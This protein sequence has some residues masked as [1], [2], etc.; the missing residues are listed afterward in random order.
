MA[1][2][3]DVFCSSA[4]RH[5][6]TCSVHS[7]AGRFCLSGVTFCLTP[8]RLAGWDGERLPVAWVRGRE[9][10]PSHL[11]AKL[12]RLGHTVL[13]TSRF[14]LSPVRLQ[15]AAPKRVLRFTCHASWSQRLRMS[16]RHS[17]LLSYTVRTIQGC[18][19]CVEIEHGSNMT[20]CDHQGREKI[21]VLCGMRSLISNCA[22]R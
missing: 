18:T 3:R 8:P 11:A 4:V 15:S 13:M 10:T 5:F 22:R 14:S 17:A 16:I 1:C 7:C 21:T 12:T 6:S 20:S 2:S 19:A 9:L